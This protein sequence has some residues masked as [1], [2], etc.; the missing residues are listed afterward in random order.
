VRVPVV[1]RFAIHMLLHAAAPAAAARL[2]W[3]DH[4]RK[5]WLVM[6]ATMIVDLD[7]LL[8]RPMFD[9]HR[10][11]IGLHPL[12]TWPAIAVYVVLAAIPKSRWVGVGLLIH[13]ALDALD[14]WMM[15]CC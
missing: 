4:W 5:A 12:H 14:C 2:G 13:M 8:A 15:H 1:L 10:C 6:M 7:H 9:A 3:R 11:S